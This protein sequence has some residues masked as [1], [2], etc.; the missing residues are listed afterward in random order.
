MKEPTRLQLIEDK[1]KQLLNEAL[2]IV[3][4]KYP[5]V[6]E[7]TAWSSGSMSVWTDQQQVSPSHTGYM[8]AASK[9]EDKT[10]KKIANLKAELAKLEATK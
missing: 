7:V 5:H 4:E 10:A 9:L 2:A 1:L 8:D 6:A 3:Q